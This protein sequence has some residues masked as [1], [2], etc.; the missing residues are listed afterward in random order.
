MW[1]PGSAS[2]T[3]ATSRDPA[4]GGR[5]SRTGTSRT[6]AS[7]RA[8]FGPRSF[9]NAEVREIGISSDQLFQAVTSGK[10][11]RLARGTYVVDEPCRRTL[12]LHLQHELT[13][14]G[15]PSV[16]GGCSA[17]HIWDIPIIG[18]N[19]P[20]ADCEPLLWVPPGSMRQGIRHGVHVIHGDVPRNHTS[21]A[22]DGLVLTSP[23]RTAVDVVRLARL[24]RTFA[25]ATLNGGLR[26]HLAASSKVPLAQAG[27]VT[28]L[29]QDPRARQ[30]LNRELAAV[31]ADV[32]AWGIRSVRDCLPF[33]DARLENAFESLSWGRFVEAGVELPEPQ[34]WLQGASGRWYRVDFWW[35]DL[36]L[37][38]EADGMVK[39]TEPGALAEEKARQLDLEGPGRSMIRW[40]WGHVLPDHDPLFDALIARIRSAAS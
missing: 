1:T 14:R 8:A 3:A 16:A 4:R 33:A 13:R 12:L 38:G 26:A 21:L 28:R 7:L 36:G 32:P 25:L 6:A 15:I 31:I 22:A 30:R 2:G 34:A 39:Y 5:S 24:S 40:G 19:D 18:A 27:L 35:S 11:H 29:A 17:A 37:I 20:A 10:V 9:T 23:L